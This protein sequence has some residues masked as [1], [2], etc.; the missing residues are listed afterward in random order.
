VAFVLAGGYTSSISM[1]ELVD[2]HLHTIRA[3]GAPVCVA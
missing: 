3:F 1:K 2:L